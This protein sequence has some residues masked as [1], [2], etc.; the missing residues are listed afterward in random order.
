MDDQPTPTSAVEAEIASLE[1]Q[2]SRVDTKAAF[3]FGFT[4]VSIIGGSALVNSLDLRPLGS[5]MALVSIL[6]LVASAVFLVLAVRPVLGK[7]V[8]ESSGFPH[9]AVL[10]FDD[11]A[12][13]VE[14]SRDPRA[15]CLYLANLSRLAVTKFRRIRVAV[16]L[17]LTGIGLSV[18][19]CLV[20]ASFG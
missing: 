17:I 3:L 2:L 6:P 4:G 14:E 20:I 11:L 10:P 9:Y 18:L 13:A 5:T 19:S 1:V 8:S 12:Q 16:D 7:S 15:R